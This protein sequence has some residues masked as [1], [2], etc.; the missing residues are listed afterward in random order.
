MAEEQTV[1]MSFSEV[2]AMLRR[3]EKTYVSSVCLDLKSPYSA[4]IAAKPYLRGM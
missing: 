2:D 1:F 4:Q 3:E